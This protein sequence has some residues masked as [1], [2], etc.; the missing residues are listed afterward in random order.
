MNSFCRICTLQI[1]VY[2]LREN[3]RGIL[4][5]DAVTIFVFGRDYP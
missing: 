4:L 1:P 2:L 3:G 5:R